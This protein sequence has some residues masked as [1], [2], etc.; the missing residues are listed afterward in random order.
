MSEK[1]LRV[2]LAEGSPGETAAALRALYLEDQDNLELTNVSSVST[3]IATL[4][5]VNPEVI[6]LDLSLAVPNPLV[7]VRRVHRSAPGVPLI[8]LA[9]DSEKHCAVQSLTQGA[10]DYLVKGFIDTKT[11]ERVLR[12]ALEHNTLEGLADLL[13]DSQTGL[14]IRDGFLTLAEHAM[15]AAKSKGSTLVLLCL[16]IENVQALRD[17]FGPGAVE[18]CS[19]EVA[20]LLSGS[21]RRTDIVG[22]IGERQ[23][24]ALAVDAAEPSAPVLCQRLQKRIAILN[25]DIGPLGPLELRMSARFWSPKESITFSQFLDIVEAGLQSEPIQSSEATASDTTVHTG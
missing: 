2:L 21:F 4:E 8:V 23:F 10:Q 13:R 12:V 3:L 15:E 7:E 14:Y 19:C 22:R 16:R 5:V 17:E 18:K 6:F 9:Q 25:R 1:K 24:A 11:L 20:K